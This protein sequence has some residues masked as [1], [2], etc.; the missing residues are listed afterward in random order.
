MNASTIIAID[1]ILKQ[2]VSIA[3]DSFENYK[4]NMDTKYQQETWRMS[5]TEAKVCAD[6]EQ[7]YKEISKIYK[8]FSEHQW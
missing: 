2:K 7:E 3:K 8:D 6:L 4:W 5:S 1:G